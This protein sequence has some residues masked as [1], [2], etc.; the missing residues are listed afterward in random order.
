MSK[1]S[2]E[3]EKKIKEEILRLLYENYPKMFYTKNIADD[4]IRN[5]EFILKLMKELNKDDLVIN[6]KESKGNKIKRKWGLNQGTY[7]EYK[8][9]LS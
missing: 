3:K 5:D 1:V 9:L 2:I 6:L 8:N 4:L 7:K